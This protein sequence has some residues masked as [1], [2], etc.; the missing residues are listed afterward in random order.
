M[1]GKTENNNGF[2][3]LFTDV[4]SFVELKADYVQVGLVEKLTKLVSKLL[5]LF[6]SIVIGMAILFYLLLALAYALAPTLGFI[7]SF[8][9]IAGVFFILLAVVL[10]FRKSM[11][12]NPILKVMVD[13]FYDQDKE[14]KLNDE[15]DEDN[16]AAI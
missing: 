6:L 5:I 7:A 15:N 10:L 8:A 3:K 13:V 9:I 11:I 12:I 1:S 4:K 16:A 2:Q 14:N